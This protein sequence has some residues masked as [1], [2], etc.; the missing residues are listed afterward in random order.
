[1]KFVSEFVL[2]LIGAFGCILGGMWVSTQQIAKMLHYPVEF[3]TPLLIKGSPIYWP[4]FMLW[5]FTYGDYAPDAFEEAAMA[6]VIGAC[7]GIAFILFFAFARV[8]PKNKKQLTSHGTAS[9]ATESEIKE[10]DLM[11]GRGVVLGTTFDNQYL[12]HDGPEHL[13][14]VAPTGSGK[15]IGHVI[16]T[17]ASPAWPESVVV[18]DIKRENWIKTSRYRKQALKNIVIKFEPTNGDG[19]SA[20][21]NPLDEIRIR[22]EYEAADVQNLVYMMVFSDEKAGKG[23]PHW[24]ISAADFLFGVVLHLKYI[25]PNA[26]LPSVAAY[27]RQKQ[28]EEIIA[29]MMLTEHVEDET[30]FQR[31]Y[32]DSI[33][34]D[35]PKTHPKVFEA[36]MKMNNTPEKERGSIFSTAVAKFDL[37]KDPVICRNVEQSNFKIEDLMDHDKPVS[38]Y[39]VTPPGELPRLKSLFR[40]MVDLIFHKLTGP[41]SEQKEEVHKHRLL[42]MIDEFPA[43]ERMDKI[44]AALAWA[45]GYK[46][47]IALVI[48]DMNQIYQYYTRDNSIIGNAKVRIF[49]TPESED[50]KKFISTA[51]GNRTEVV[52]NKSYQRSFFGYFLKSVTIS[53]QESARPLMYPDE[54]G[55]MPMEQEIIFTSGKAPILAKKI[56]YYED[57][58]FARGVLPPLEKSDLIYEDKIFAPI[59][60]R[61]PVVADPTP[62]VPQITDDYYGTHIDDEFEDED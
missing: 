45:R 34:A 43:L 6:S 38:L 57:P 18:L 35:Q 15:G 14:L 27:L 30:F 3:G 2:Y 7:I 37:Y 56:K 62:S 1:M 26:S 10:S 42:L 20:K 22:T 17:L 13:L 44:Q 36:G 41:M 40:I 21:F 55:K 48:Q 61:Q 47:K 54:V 25:Q 31:I 59:G 50:T 19:T 51:L 12:C 53:T 33:V 9:W 11:S 60:S 8:M 28:L 5:W 49:H 46:I 24:P 23:D 32:G 16:P 39:L 4:E 52:E 29:E 58:V